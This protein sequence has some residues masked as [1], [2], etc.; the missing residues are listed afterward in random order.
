MVEGNEGKYIF[1]LVE[2]VGERNYN[3]QN[4]AFSKKWVSVCDHLL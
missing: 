2:K 4:K 3:E 1:L